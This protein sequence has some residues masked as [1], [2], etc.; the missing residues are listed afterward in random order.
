MK[1]R[2][3]QLKINSKYSQLNHRG[4]T[5]IE[6]V[7][8]IAIISLVLV[9]AFTIAI[10]LR[11][12]VIAQER[13]IT[14]QQEITLIRNDFLA[15]IDASYFYNSYFLDENEEPVFEEIVIDFVNCGDYL[16]STSGPEFCSLFQ[17]DF[18]HVND[19][20]IFLTFREV[21]I[22]DQESI[23]IDVIIKTNFFGNRHVDVQAMI[24]ILN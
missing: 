23:L 14:A 22:S 16:L 18:F 10:N 17:D 12:Q 1:K 19:T 4:V 24:T 15:R 21:L 20:R 11:T 3:H 13:R 5:L 7:A 6:T 8:A 9:S 2:V